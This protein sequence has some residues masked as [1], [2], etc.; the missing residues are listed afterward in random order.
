MS[1]NS[2]NKQ[3]PLQGSLTQIHGKQFLGPRAVMYNCE[4]DGFGGWRNLD[5][6][7]VYRHEVWF[8]GKY[9]RQTGAPV[10]QVINIDTLSGR[11]IAWIVGGRA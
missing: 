3:W 10:E 4:A 2:G 5:T 9:M 7:P 8:T 6:P 1:V 11:E